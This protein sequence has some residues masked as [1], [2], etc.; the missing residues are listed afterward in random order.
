MVKCSKQYDKLYNAAEDV[1]RQLIGLNHMVTD[2]NITIIRND[3]DQLWNKLKMLTSQVHFSINIIKGKISKISE[4]IYINFTKDCKGRRWSKNIYQ[5]A[6]KNIPTFAKHIITRQVSIN[7]LMEQI[8]ESLNQMNGQYN[9]TSNVIDD[10]SYVESFAIS[11]QELMTCME[12]AIQCNSEF[13]CALSKGSSFLSR[14]KR[15]IPIAIIQ[16]D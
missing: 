1:H 13:M 15:Q 16:I 6:S 5:F 12:N 11:L 4:K 2:N 8:N 3:V 14:I 7:L 10:R 9:S